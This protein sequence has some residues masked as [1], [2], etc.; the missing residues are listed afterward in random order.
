MNDS[1]KK[2]LV[3]IV[4]DSIASGALYA[5]QLEQVGHECKHFTDG[6]S[7]LVGIKEMMLMSLSKMFVYPI[8]VA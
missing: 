3:Y 2:S 5:S 4:E 1:Q 8:L 6:Y 7:A